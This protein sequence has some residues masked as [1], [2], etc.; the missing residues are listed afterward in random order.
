MVLGHQHIHW[1]VSKVNYIS[2]KFLWMYNQL[3]ICWC[4]RCLTIVRHLIHFFINIFTTGNYML[5]FDMFA[6]YRHITWQQRSNRANRQLHG[7][8]Y[9]LFLNEMCSHSWQQTSVTLTVRDWS[10]WG[11]L[12]TNEIDNFRTIHPAYFAFWHSHHLYQKQSTGRYVKI[13]QNCKFLNFNKCWKTHLYQIWW[14]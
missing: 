5:T 10:K 4:I 14:I 11:I 2:A 6:M 13:R 7:V 12:T 9:L 1:W 3:G 8:R